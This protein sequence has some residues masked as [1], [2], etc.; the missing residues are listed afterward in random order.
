[1]ARR[2]KRRTYT[3][4]AKRYTRGLFGM[5]NMQTIIKNAGAGALVGFL[6]SKVPNDALGGYGDSLVPL[7]VGMVM[8]NH[9]LQTLGAYQL[10]IKLASNFAG[11]ESTN[12][13][14]AY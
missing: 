3:R 11:G 2:K 4:R 6:Q 12:V 10:G 9:T 13:G 8:K 14:G 7:G 1:M 5:S